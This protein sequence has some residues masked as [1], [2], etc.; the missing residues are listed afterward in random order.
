MERFGDG[1]PVSD[2]SSLLI[3]TALRMARRWCG[4]PADAEDIAQEALILLLRQPRRPANLPA[5]LFVVT[6]RLSHRHRMRALAR[7]NAEAVFDGG[8]VTAAQDH[9]L[10]IDVRLVIARLGVRDQKLLLALVEGA[11]SSEIASAFGC[12]VRDVGQMVS[13]ARKKALQ[14][15]NDGSPVRK[16]PR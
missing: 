11:V 10:T 9:E 14:L 12:R 4:S 7:V 15:R 2:D 6:R 3:R 8:R 16:R 13:R 5:W 1:D